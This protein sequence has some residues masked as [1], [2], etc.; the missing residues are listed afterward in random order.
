[1]HDFVLALHHVRGRLLCGHVLVPAASPRDEAVQASPHGVA[2]HG[3]AEHLDT[4]V[5]VEEREV[6]EDDNAHAEGQPVVADEALA[7]DHAVVQLTNVAVLHAHAHAKLVGVLLGQVK[8]HGELRVVELVVP[9]KGELD[10][11]ALRV[12]VAVLPHQGKELLRA[13]E[14]VA[15]DNQ[16][17]LRTL[18]EGQERSLPAL[19]VRDDLQVADEERHLLGETRQVFP[20]RQS[21]EEVIPLDVVLARPHDVVLRD[22]RAAHAT[23]HRQGNI[24]KVPGRARTSADE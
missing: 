19:L 12:G 2:P 3:G 23:E 16:S 20:L 14:D 4:E 22:V 7:L 11:V 17:A 13:D 9:G 18:E 24:P 21:D 8:E 1:M 6:F 5:V 10:G 15:L